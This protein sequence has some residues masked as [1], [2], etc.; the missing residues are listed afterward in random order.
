MNY[1]EQLGVH[2]DASLNEIER[3]IKSAAQTQKIDINTLRQI[4]N[5]LRNPEQRRQY[6][7]ELRRTQPDF[8]KAEVLNVDNEPEVAPAPHRKSKK[9]GQ[10]GGESLNLLSRKFLM[11]AYIMGLVGCL[12]PWVN[13]NLMSIL[14]KNSFFGNFM[15]GYLAW[16]YPVMWVVAIVLGINLYQILRSDWDEQPAPSL[17]KKLCLSVSMIS[18]VFLFKSKFHPEQAYSFLFGA[19]LVMA[20]AVLIVVSHWIKS[21][22]EMSS[23]QVA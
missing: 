8:F 4:A 5:T 2:H 21:E 17:V 3:A 10:I 6:T 12:L 20:A 18:C 23:F 1:Y 11:A 14:V 7:Q 15:T 19:Y 22:T 16:N 9:R 13:T